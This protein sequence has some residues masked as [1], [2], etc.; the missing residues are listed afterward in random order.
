M[1]YFVY[2][3]KSIKEFWEFIRKKI[4]RLS[5]FFLNLLY[6]PKY[7]YLRKY[8]KRIIIYS[9]YFIDQ[10]GIQNSGSNVVHSVL[11]YYTEGPGFNPR[12]RY[13]GH[14]AGASRRAMA[15]HRE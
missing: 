7:F 10:I 11:D 14:Y 1:E 6:K 4:V 5:L 12:S 3:A 8:N 2:F 15:N 9:T 13:N